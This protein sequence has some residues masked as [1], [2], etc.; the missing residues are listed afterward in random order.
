MEGYLAK[1]SLSEDFEQLKLGGI[2]LFRAFL[3]H[4]GDVDL[5]DLRFLLGERKGE[6]RRDGFFYA[7]T[8]EETAKF[9]LRAY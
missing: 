5:L 2:C 7:T 9:S 3:D 4:M 8:N 1:G 6:R